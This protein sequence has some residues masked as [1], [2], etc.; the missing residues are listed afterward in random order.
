[1]DL[2]EFWGSQVRLTV[3]DHHVFV[4]HV[5]SVVSQADNDDK[6]ESI[7]FRP[8][9]GSLKGSLLEIMRSEILEISKI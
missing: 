8:D 9:S 1:M 6:E 2:L 4:G 3:I 7:L 5:D